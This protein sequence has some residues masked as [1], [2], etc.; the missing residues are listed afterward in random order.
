NLQQQIDAI[1]NGTSTGDVSALQDQQAK[2]MNDAQ[3]SAAQLD[4]DLHTAPVYTSQGQPG[5]DNPFVDSCES[6][7]TAILPDTSTWMYG[8]AN[9]DIDDTGDG[10]GVSNSDTWSNDWTSAEVP[11][12]YSGTSSTASTDSDPTGVQERESAMGSLTDNL[13][14]VGQMVGEYL[15]NHIS[16]MNETYSI[17]HSF[18]GGIVDQ[19]KAMVQ[20]LQQA[21]S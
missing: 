15:K 16:N 8:S 6:S 10:V 5:E 18:D 20:N 2:L 4:Y 12:Q 13:T 9:P 21:G 19:E 7:L 17:E 14:S 1:N 3:T 11:T